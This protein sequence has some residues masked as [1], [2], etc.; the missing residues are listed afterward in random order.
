MSV[1]ITEGRLSPRHR[2]NRRPDSY[3]NLRSNRSVM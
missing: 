2:Q 3:R 1:E